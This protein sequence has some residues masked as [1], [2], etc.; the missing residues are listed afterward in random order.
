ML[1]RVMFADSAVALRGR[2]IS[3]EEGDFSL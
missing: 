3:G 1:L 2:E